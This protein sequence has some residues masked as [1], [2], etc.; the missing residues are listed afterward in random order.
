MGSAV[1]K[2]YLSLI[3]RPVLEHTLSA[4]LAHPAVAGVVVALAADDGRW[5]ALRLPIGKPVYRCTGGSDRAASVAAGLDLLA[6]LPRPPGWVLVHDAAR[7]CLSGEALDRLFR[8]LADEP[9]G[10]LLAVPMNDTVKSSSD[11]ERVSG[12]LDRSRLW[13]AQTPQLFR[14]AP[15]R[16]ALREAPAGVV[17]DEASA[18]EWLGWRP[19]LVPGDE[20]NL[21]ITRPGDVA[22]AEALLRELSTGGG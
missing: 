14:L 9:L 15:L 7:P 17:T 2:Q 22:M 11:G 1:P 19:R 12:T 8:A 3:G 6:G 18:L 21:K 4:L 20:R 13:R 16:R 5:D 10:G